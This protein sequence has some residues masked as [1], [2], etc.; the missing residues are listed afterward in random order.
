M[1]LSSVLAS[2]LVLV[3]L[4]CEAGPHSLMTIKDNGYDNIL[5]AIHKDVKEESKIVDEIQKMFQDGSTYFYQ[6]SR[7]RAFFRN[8]TI[9]I[10]DTWQDKP[11]YETALRENYEISDIRVAPENPLYGDLPYTKQPGQCGDPGEYVHFTPGYVRDDPEVNREYKWG[12]AGRILVHE[13]AHLRYGVFDEYGMEEDENYPL[14]YLHGRR[15]R[16]TGCTTAVMGRYLTKTSFGRCQ[17]DRNTGLPEKDCRFFPELKRN[18]AKASIMFYQFIDSVHAFCENKPQDRHHTHNTLA[19]NMQNKLCNNAG[20]WDVIKQHEDFTGSNN[21]ARDISDTSPKFRLVY[22]RPVRRAV[23]NKVIKGKRVVMVLDMSWSMR[24]QNRL[25]KM[26]QAA[27]IFIRDNVPVG[28]EIGVIGFH[29]NATILENLTIIESKTDAKQMSNR[30]N[31]ALTK[32]GGN[33]AIGKGLLQAIDSLGKDGISPEGSII[34]LITDGQQNV[35]PYTWELFANRTLETAGV[36]VNTIAFGAQADDILEEV[37]KRTGGMSF[38]DSEAKGSTGLA[39]ALDRLGEELA[40][41][42]STEPSVQVNAYTVDLPRKDDTHD[43]S[44]FIDETIGKNTEFI[45]TYLEYGGIS[46]VLRDPS[47][48]TYTV[49]SPQYEHDEPVRIVRVS[50]PSAQVGLWKY[51]I[52]NTATTKQTVQVDVKSRS[53]ENSQPIR[54]RAWMS[55]TNVDVQKARAVVYAEVSKGYAPI[56]NAKVVATVDRPQGD[57]LELELKDNGAGADNQKD[58][59]VYSAYFTNFNGNGRYGVSAKVSME[60][61]KAGVKTAGS[62]ASAAAYKD[63]SLAPTIVAVVS[64]LPSGITRATPGGAFRVTGANGTDLYPP[65]RVTDLKVASYSYADQTV[66]LAWTAPGGDLDYGTAASYTL[67]Q[68]TNAS[69]LT[70]LSQAKVVSKADVMFGHLDPLPSGSLQTVTIKVPSAGDDVEY[71]FALIARDGNGNTSPLSSYAT[72]VMRTQSNDGLSM[73]AIGA[74]IGGTLGG[75]VIVCVTVIVVA[76][77]MSKN[78]VKVLKAGNSSQVN[79]TIADSPREDM[80]LTPKPYLN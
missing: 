70:D 42:D 4:R 50:I 44:V 45:F 78:K 26:T 12:E 36:T 46:V 14:F 62:K 32:E 16:V 18:R 76:K 63:P 11:E 55:A 35:E 28:T 48:K 43:K 69:L 73:G 24:K 51:T 41:E 6:A 79:L 5:V 23:D 22:K 10:P 7:K 38:Y 72:A 65:S 64:P 61:G 3:V 1:Q 39:S 67:Y 59:G 49:G 34:I 33:T 31:A 57:P 37:G 56:V 20:T 74:I 2:V 29:D 25:R 80:Y 30:L 15:P 9:L 8:V 66:T 17:L 21:P 53:R 27:S 19:P 68:T 58:D 13:F 40:L 54:V 52:T 60:D 71:A 75:L 77:M 47:G